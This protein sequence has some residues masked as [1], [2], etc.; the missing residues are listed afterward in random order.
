MKH[1][2]EKTSVAPFASAKCVHFYCGSVVTMMLYA[3]Y[4][5]PD[6][7]IILAFSASRWFFVVS[8]YE[9]L[10]HELDGSKRNTHHCQNNRRSFKKRNNISTLFFSSITMM[11]GGENATQKV[12]SQIFEISLVEG[13]YVWYQ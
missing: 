13:D 12:L 8:S 2:D 5:R 4:S 3:V 7:P 10:F 9:A 11:C 1:D 6:R